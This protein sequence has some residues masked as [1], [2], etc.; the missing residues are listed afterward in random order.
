MKVQSFEKQFPE[1][2]AW[3]S[4][5]GLVM[6]LCFH[7]PTH[8]RISANAF[9]SKPPLPHCS[10]TVGSQLTL[11][12]SGKLTCGFQTGASQNN[13]ATPPPTGSQTSDLK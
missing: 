12:F 1:G 4:W 9:L 8:S 10:P 2:A 7:N 3:R 6:T 13:L 5:V 11:R